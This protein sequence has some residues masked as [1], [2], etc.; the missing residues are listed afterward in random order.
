[1]D[2][3]EVD[4]LCRVCGFDIGGGWDGAAPLYIICACCGA[5]SGLEDDPAERALAYL[6][7]WV[8]VGSPWFRPEERPADWDLRDQ[9][10]AAGLRHSL[11]RLDAYADGSEPRD[12]KFARFPVRPWWLPPPVKPWWRRLPF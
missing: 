4:D 6:V 7:E 2:G 12:P 3:P 5:E 8:A 1:M 11:R 10:V 9:L